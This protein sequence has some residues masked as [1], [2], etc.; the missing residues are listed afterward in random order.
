MPKK[1]RILG[2]A[3]AA[4]FVTL[5]EP[6]VDPVTGEVMFK[7]DITASQ[8]DF[9]V[10]QMNYHETMR[11]A[12]AEQ[13]FD[14]LKGLPPE[15]A[16]QLLDMAFELTDLPNK[17]VFAQRI[18]QINGMPEPGQEKDPAYLQQKADEAKGA[19]MRQQLADENVAADTRVKNTTADKNAADAK[20]KAVEGK[21]GALNLAAVLEAAVPLA[22]AADRLYDPDQGAETAPPFN[23]APE[24][25]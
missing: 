21:A 3:G 15:T 11:M 25:P 23:P 17:D 24:S 19:Q 16:L 2:P 10:D 8:A 12:M 5:N 20:S 6:V 13:V 4:K 1:F 7:N 18:R 22:P 9:V 14:S